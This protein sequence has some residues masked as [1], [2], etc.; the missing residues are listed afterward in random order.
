VSARFERFVNAFDN[1]I[2]NE[3]ISYTV[4]FNE[5]KQNSFVKSNQNSGASISL[6]K[7]AS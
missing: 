1:F 5:V 7:A 4:T 6:S 3:N 2:K